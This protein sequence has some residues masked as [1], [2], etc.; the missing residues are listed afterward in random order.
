MVNYPYG[1][2]FL[3]GLPKWPF[4]KACNLTI[5]NEIHGEKSS[6]ELRGIA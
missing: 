3:A 4:N 5:Q 6:K 1:A 2:N